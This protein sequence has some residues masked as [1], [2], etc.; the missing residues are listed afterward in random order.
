MR[1]PLQTLLF[2]S[3]LAAC[4]SSQANRAGASPRPS[5]LA[6]AKPTATSSGESLAKP[7]S[8]I[9][10]TLVV[11]GDI[12]DLPGF[13]SRLY[14]VE[15]PPGAQADAHTHTEQCAGYV[16]EGS[17]ASS[18]GDGPATVKHTAEAFID[19]PGQVHH[20]KNLDS[21]RPLRFLVAGSFRKEEPLLRPISD[22]QGS[23]TGAE[24]P[25]PASVP[26]PPSGP[27][28]EVK[29]SLLAQQE[30]ADLPG[31]E[32]RIYLMEF[33]PGAASKLHL[34]TAQGIGYVLE[35]SFE[36]AFGDD[37]VVTKRA[38]DGF[39]DT[40]GKPHH[41]RNPD[42]ARPLRFV[43]AGMFHKDEPLFKVLSE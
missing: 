26:E 8:G 12:A 5:T 11:R 27:V 36:S 14:L 30:I 28:A 18:Y 23:A 39:V 10:R 32:S 1:Y 41:F 33:P 38:G 15:Y 6:S 43:F 31:M 21:A 40:P 20:F 25:A 37:P 19:L 7:A 22:G 9:K 29:R 3:T 34:H 2:C 24:P 42:P 16:I 4:S 17:F 13:E 35:G